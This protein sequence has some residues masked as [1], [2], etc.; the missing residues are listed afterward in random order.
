MALAFQF[1]DGLD[2]GA[3]AGAIALMILG[4]TTPFPAEVSAIGV[5]MRHDFATG[6]ALVWSGAML[7]ALLSYSL[8]YLLAD[9][10]RWLTS[11]RS[12]QAA[13]LRIRDLGWLG[14]LGLR[15]IPFVPFFALSLAAGILRVRLGAYLLGTG[16]GILPATTLL[17][18]AGQG[19]I[20]DQ[21]WKLAIA[22]VGLAG[23]L[24]VVMLLRHRWRARE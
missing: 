12:V 8:A 5:A 4:T 24:I 11:L 15:L 1:P 2:P 17:T 16:L 3:P 7:G 18:L 19:L 13:K 22:L 14:I 9:R 6:F 21:G 23:G 20:S 10:A